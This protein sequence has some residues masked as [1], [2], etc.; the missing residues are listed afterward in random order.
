MVELLLMS[1]TNERGLR[2]SNMDIT[3][4][5]P[6]HYET[7]GSFIW[8][9]TEG[10]YVIAKEIDGKQKA[11]YVGLG[12]IRER[13]D[14]HEGKSEPNSC[15]K[16]IMSDR[17]NLKIHY[18]TITNQTD[19]ENAEFTLFQLYG[20]LVKLCNLVTPTGTYDYTINGPFI[21]KIDF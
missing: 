4:N 15:L 9:K 8:P 21:Q 10:V 7:G 11:Q 2:I 1:L 3:W 12:N 20:G 6:I 13:M 5:K 19:R 18:A 14:E 16:K 17:D